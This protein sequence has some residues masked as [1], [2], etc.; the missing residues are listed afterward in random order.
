MLSFGTIKVLL[1][2]DELKKKLDSL[3]PDIMDENLTFELFRSQITKKK[4]I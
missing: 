1:S 3:A 4:K 2:E